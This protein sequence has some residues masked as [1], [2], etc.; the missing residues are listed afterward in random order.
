MNLNREEILAQ[1]VQLMGVVAALPD[2]LRSDAKQIS[3]LSNSLGNLSCDVSMITYEPEKADDIVIREVAV[4]FSL[5]E[6]DYEIHRM[7][8]SAI[9]DRIFT[10]IA[11]KAPQV[12]MERE[13]KLLKR[14]VDVLEEKYQEE[15]F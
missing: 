4:K 8:I 7:R 3:D 9:T 11:F 5:K 1:L 10:L 14:A 2:D 6:R 12:I 13:F 15:R